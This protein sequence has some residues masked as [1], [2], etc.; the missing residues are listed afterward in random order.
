M[1][2]KFSFDPRSLGLTETELNRK[3]VD[4][5]HTVAETLKGLSEEIANASRERRAIM[6]THSEIAEKFVHDINVAEDTLLEI[7]NTSSAQERAE[8]AKRSPLSAKM[9]VAVYEEEAR[10]RE[11]KEK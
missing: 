6:A 1:A 3:I 7:R 5:G 2:I 10:R 4:S 11:G 9:V 8:I